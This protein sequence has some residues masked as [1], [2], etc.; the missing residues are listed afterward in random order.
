MNTHKFFG[1]ALS[2]MVA[3]AAA[4]TLT[5]C[6]GD[7]DHSP[8]SETYEPVAVEM[9][10]SFTVNDEL[11]TYA[12]L[13]VEYFGSDGL[14]H[15]EP[16]TERTWNK[17]V[18]AALPATLGACL[19]PTEKEGV[20]LPSKERMN[21]DNGYSYTYNLLDKNDGILNSGG[22]SEKG[23]STPKIAQLPDWFNDFSKGL[24]MFLRRFDKNGN[25]HQLTWE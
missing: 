17:S 13:T 7:D 11:L 5:A 2:A 25:V 14:L 15:K 10:I 12:N 20:E 3:M 23:K 6:G 4:M 16:M 19:V 18:K 21:F 8:S 24:T 22:Y 1:I 9:N